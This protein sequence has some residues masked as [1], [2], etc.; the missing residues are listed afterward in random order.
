MSYFKFFQ[1]LKNLLVYTHDIL[2][3]PFNFHYYLLN[4]LEYWQILLAIHAIIREWVNMYYCI[5]HLFLEL[6]RILQTLMAVLT[7]YI[8]I[9]LIL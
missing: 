4:L 7:V 9:I 5:Y 3:V 1:I 2:R 8:Y 6:R